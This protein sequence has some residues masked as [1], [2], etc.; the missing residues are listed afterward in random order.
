MLQK[1]RLMKEQKTQQGDGEEQLE[2]VE[3]QDRQELYVQKSFGSTSDLR[4]AKQRKKMIFMDKP[5]DLPY[6]KGIQLPKH[7]KWISVTSVSLLLLQTYAESERKR[8]STGD[9][10]PRAGS[11]ETQ[12]SQGYPQRIPQIRADAQ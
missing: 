10:S 3:V 7:L 11:L 5:L 9:P 12:R 4:Q 8:A 2:V 6:Y 1:N